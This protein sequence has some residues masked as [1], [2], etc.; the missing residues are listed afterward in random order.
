MK[1][2][3]SFLLLLSMLV[4]MIPISVFAE[5]SE[6]QERSSRDYDFTD[7]SSTASWDTVDLGSDNTEDP[8]IEFDIT[9]KAEAVDGLVG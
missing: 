5:N 4:S 6:R 7:Y 2:I 1:K 9:P 8:I 3:V